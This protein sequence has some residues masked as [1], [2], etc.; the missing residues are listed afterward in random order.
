MPLPFREVPMKIIKL[1][2]SG[3]AGGVLRHPH[4]GAL[5]VS[6]DDAKRLVE[7][8]KVAEDVTGD[9]SKAQ[10]AALTP[11]NTDGPAVDAGSADAPENPH[12]AEVAPHADDEKPEPK[13]A[14]RKAAE[15]KE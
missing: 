8:E 6:D 4:E 3:Y 13:P 9:F 1:S 12:Q 7:D 10:L 2:T 5:P 11:E 15:D 14:R